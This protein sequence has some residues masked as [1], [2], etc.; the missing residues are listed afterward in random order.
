MGWWSL[1]M[2]VDGLDLAEVSS[3]LLRIDGVD[4]GR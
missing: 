1:L 3:V 4:M 2:V